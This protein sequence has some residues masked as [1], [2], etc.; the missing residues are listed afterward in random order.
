MVGKRS[1]G[2]GMEGVWGREVGIGGGRGVF[3]NFFFFE[4]TGLY[5]ERGCVGVVGDDVACFKRGFGKVGY[6]SMV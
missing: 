3:W 2:D 4:K 5:G 6:V 1:V